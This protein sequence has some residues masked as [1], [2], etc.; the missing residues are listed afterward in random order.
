MDVSYCRTYLQRNIN[1]GKLTDKERVNHVSCYDLERPGFTYLS[2]KNIYIVRAKHVFCHGFCHRLK[3][4][5]MAPSFRCSLMCQPRPAT[6]MYRKHLDSSDSSD[7]NDISDS[8]V[9]KKSLQEF[10]TVCVR[11]RHDLC[12][13]GHGT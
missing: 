13:G 2:N 4:M 5:A 7:N 3:A 12:F 1:F 9:Q 8:G 10:L 11:S 6:G